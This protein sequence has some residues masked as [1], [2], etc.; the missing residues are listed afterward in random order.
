[1]GPQQIVSLIQ[2]LARLGIPL[3]QFTGIDIPGLGSLNSLLGLTNSVMNNNIPGA[4]RGG[5]NLGSQALN[6]LDM[7]G[8]SQAVGALGGPLSLATGI[9]NGNPLSAIMGG[10][11]TASTISGAL[12]GPTIS[13]MASSLG[14]PAMPSMTSMAPLALPAFMAFGG[15]QG[16]SEDAQHGA[17]IMQRR[18]NRLTDALKTN[19]QV[20]QLGP[21]DIAQNLPGSLDLISKGLG[22]LEHLDYT[23]PIYDMN[24]SHLSDA[25]KGLRSRTGIA[26]L[27]SRDEA[28][29]QNLDTKP[30][31]ESN[32]G[33]KWG[34]DVTMWSESAND[35]NPVLI[36]H[37]LGLPY[38]PDFMRENPGDSGTPSWNP[39]TMAQWLYTQG[40]TD[41]PEKLEELK[42][43]GF[44]VQ[45]HQGPTGWLADGVP[46]PAAPI[47]DVD[48]EKMKEFLNSEYGI[49]NL[50][51]A[52]T[53]NA[54]NLSNDQLAGLGGNASWRGPGNTT[55]DGDLA[56]DMAP[57]SPEF[58]PSIA[59]FDAARQNLNT[60]GFQPGSYI[61]ALTSFLQ[62]PMSLPK[63]PDRPVPDLFD[64]NNAYA[65]ASGGE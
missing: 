20:A 57:L 29:R 55:I 33:P 27:A 60:A 10:A 44:T 51:N 52:V 13:S 49:L 56:T 7:P 62:N 11:Q 41:T 53:D 23:Q 63:T 58:F 16:M 54:G 14:L 25:V 9:A 36:S 59:E 4:V 32:W 17:A 42:R 46:A 31:D 39:A 28:Q 50:R 12:G 1:M 64:P 47:I 30:Y 15:L 19:T 35:Q 5:I 34:S 38:T 61:D 21:Q 22:N 26:H 24:L 65:T 37:L 3:E 40:I 43:R 18:A 45:E 6:L 48:P 8:A 2:S